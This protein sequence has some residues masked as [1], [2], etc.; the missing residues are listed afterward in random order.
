MKGGKEGKDM[1]PISAVFKKTREGKSGNLKENDATKLV[2][3]P[4]QTIHN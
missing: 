3:H 4:F 1:P 2:F